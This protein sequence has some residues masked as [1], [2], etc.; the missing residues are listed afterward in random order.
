LKQQDDVVGNH[1]VFGFVKRSVIDLENVEGIGIGLRELVEK[2]LVTVAINMRELPKELLS[3]R[4]FHCP[5][6]PKGLELPLPT[7]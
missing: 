2:K 1:K 4:R 6:E 3:R 7:A 5:I